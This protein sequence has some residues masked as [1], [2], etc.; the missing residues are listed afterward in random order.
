MPAHTELASTPICSDE[1]L[2]RTMQE[3]AEHDGSATAL[4]E[5]L[6]DYMANKELDEAVE[7]VREVG[8]RGTPLAP[9]VA[10][11]RLLVRGPGRAQEAEG[12]DLETFRLKTE[13]NDDLNS[14]ASGAGVNEMALHGFVISDEVHAFAYEFIH[15]SDLRKVHQEGLA[16]TVGDTGAPPVAAGGGGG[17]L[18]RGEFSPHPWM[19]NRPCFD[20]R[21]FIIV[22]YI[23]RFVLLCENFRLRSGKDEWA[24]E[25][26]GHRKSSSRCTRGSCCCSSRRKR[27]DDRE[28]AA[29]ERSWAC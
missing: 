21:H 17:G 1:D 2:N 8:E 3:L 19:G 12:V 6:A 20:K 9:S 10:Q 16:R 26:F 15:D 5:A 13:K 23:I 22:D 28:R 24:S 25:L 18:V 14:T 27:Q 29:L 7:S 4:R 11:V